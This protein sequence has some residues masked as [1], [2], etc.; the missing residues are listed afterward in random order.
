MK[1]C[2]SS[3][4]EVLIKANWKD[5]EYNCDRP[6]LLFDPIH[7]TEMDRPKEHTKS[8]AALIVDDDDDGW[9]DPPAPPKRPATKLS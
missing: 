2:T 6:V 3:S 5:R 4:F 1:I 9:S 7:T 8:R